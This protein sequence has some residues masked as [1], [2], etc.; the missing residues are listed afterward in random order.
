MGHTVSSSSLGAS[1][2]GEKFTDLD[3]ADG[4]V[5]FAETMEVLVASLD[6]MSRESESLGFRVSWVKTKIQNFIQTV[7][8]AS[9]VSCCGEEVDIVDVFPCQITPDGKSER[10]INR[11]AGLG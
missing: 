10:K 4:A 11:R 2:G 6:V 9:S 7:D 1:F 8:Q 3:F 5:I